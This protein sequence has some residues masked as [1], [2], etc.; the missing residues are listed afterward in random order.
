MNVTPRLLERAFSAW[1]VV[2][3]ADQMPNTDIETTL[4]EEL[5][6]EGGGVLLTVQDTEFVV[7][8]EE[9]PRC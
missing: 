5:G 9:A 8:I 1:V 4:M 6:D 7:R 3:L 2:W